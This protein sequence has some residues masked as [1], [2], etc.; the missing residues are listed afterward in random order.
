MLLK[1]K[2]KEAPFIEQPFKGKK[3][4]FTIKPGE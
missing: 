2:N 4:S 3:R 1:L